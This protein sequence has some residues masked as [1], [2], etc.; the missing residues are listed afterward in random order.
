MFALAQHIIDEH[1]TQ[2]LIFTSPDT[3]VLVVAWYQFMSE[4]A[5]LNRLWLKTRIQEKRYAAI[6]ETRWIW[7]FNAWSSTSF[8]CHKWQF[9]GIGKKITLSILKYDIKYLI[10]VLKFGDS[11]LLA[12]QDECTEVAAKKEW[13]LKRAEIYTSL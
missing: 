3:D 8:S 7:M 6:H 2:Q 1:Q 12:L 13:L 9:S 10:A 4:L 5:T 11:A